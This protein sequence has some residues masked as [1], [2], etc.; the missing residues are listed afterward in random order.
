MTYSSRFC[1]TVIISAYML[2]S[3]IAQAAQD[4]SKKQIII[5]NIEKIRTGTNSLEIYQTA[6]KLAILL[7]KTSPEEIDDK[8]ITDL[9]SLLDLPAARLGIVGGL[10]HL[11][12]RAKKAVPKLLQ[13][14]K[15]E[16]FCYPQSVSL[17]DVIRS[18]L[19]KI[20]VTPPPS[21]CKEIKIWD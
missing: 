17:A 7:R 3:G 16:D 4:M 9:I 21:K 19:L 14:L 20:G 18:A 8:M 15:E 5:D 1:I 12:P 13:I 11:G 2:L 10:G 6:L